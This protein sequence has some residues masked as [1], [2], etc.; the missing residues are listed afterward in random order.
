MLP[1]IDFANIHP[2][3]INIKSNINLDSKIKS[4]E[5]YIASGG[6]TKLPEEILKDIELYI[7][8]TV[9]ISSQ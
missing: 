3:S 9:K 1:I 2:A 5:T 8:N 7:K 4:L 6:K